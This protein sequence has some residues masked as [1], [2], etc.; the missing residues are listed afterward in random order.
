MESSSSYH[1]HPFRSSCEQHIRQSA[2]EREKDYKELVSLG[3]R[4][5]IQHHCG[6]TNSQR[7]SG[8]PLVS[9]TRILC[10]PRGVLRSD[11]GQ[12]HFRSGAPLSLA[13]T[14]KAA[15]GRAN[16]PGAS[17]RRMTFAETDCRFLASP[18]LSQITRQFEIALE[19]KL[20]K[21]QGEMDDL[22]PA[23]GLDDSDVDYDRE[24][25]REWNPVERRCVKQQAQQTILPTTTPYSFTPLHLGSFLAATCG[26]LV[27]RGH[28]CS[29]YP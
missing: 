14:C 17:R 22:L 6:F 12:G 29:T 19:D 5:I 18:H 20:R 28:A 25:R 27:S 3:V 7:L 24:W 2:K 13:R 11:R 23:F 4:K 21:L 26:S 16:R 10:H 1:H 8:L 9:G 15:V